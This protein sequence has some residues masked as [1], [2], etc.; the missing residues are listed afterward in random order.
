M[1]FCLKVLTNKRPEGVLLNTSVGTSLP[2]LVN[3]K[4]GDKSTYTGYL[5]AKHH[6]HATC[7]SHLVLTTTQVDFKER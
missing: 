6:I 5:Y 7:L 3:H 1:K 4:D 2:S